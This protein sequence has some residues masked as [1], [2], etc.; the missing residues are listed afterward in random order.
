MTLEPVLP[1]LDD[2]DNPEFRGISRRSEQRQD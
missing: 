1:A 2:D